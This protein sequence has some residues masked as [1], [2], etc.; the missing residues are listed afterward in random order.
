MFVCCE[1]AVRLRCLRRADHS[2]RRVLPTAVRRCVW[3][4]K[5][6]EWRSRNPLWVAA[7]IKKNIYIHIYILV[8]SGHA[9]AHLVEV[10][11]YKPE[12]RGFDSQWCHWNFS[13]KLSFRPH[14]GPGFDSAPNRNEY[15]ECFLGGKGGRCLRLKTL[16]PSCADCH[17]IWGPQPPGTP[18]A[19]SGR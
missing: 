3:S 8:V 4:R 13:L 11:R 1:C 6:Q 9:V 18:R 12:C 17:E 7:P 5:P 2:S 14:Y 15:Q 19:C 10:L 16:P